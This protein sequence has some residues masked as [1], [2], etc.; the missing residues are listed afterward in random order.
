VNRPLT[1]PRSAS[2]QL[3]SGILGL[4]TWVSGSLSL[5]VAVEALVVEEG[6]RSQAGSIFGTAGRKDG[7]ASTGVMGALRCF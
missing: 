3:S 1:P 6:P 7:L 5:C 2:G 4:Q